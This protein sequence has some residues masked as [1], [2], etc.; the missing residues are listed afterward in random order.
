M[1]TGILSVTPI[2]AD[3]RDLRAILAD[4]HGPIHPV[5]TMEETL[6]RLTRESVPVIVCDRDLPDGDWK[7]LFQQTETLPRPPR[8]IV[9][10]RLADD[11]LWVEVL[12]VGGHDLLRTPFLARE[13]LHAVESAWS[14]WQRQW[15][16]TR[17]AARRQTRPGTTEDSLERRSRGFGSCAD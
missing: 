14:S 11:Y 12:T 10:S 15:A 3:Q 7:L 2:E 8:L 9:S 4:G 6:R 1:L 5:R 17:R 16:P 13:V